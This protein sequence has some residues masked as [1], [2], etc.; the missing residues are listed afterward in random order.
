MYGPSD[1]QTAVSV[2]F[3]QETRN[4]ERSSSW[5]RSSDYASI[6]IPAGSDTFGR[7]FLAR[8]HHTSPRLLVNKET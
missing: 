1:R 4:L 8:F 2:T 3:M 5:D 7:Q 6:T